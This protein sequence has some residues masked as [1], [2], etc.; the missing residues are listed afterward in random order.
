MK[1]AAPT[2]VP[3]DV[4][5]DV[6]PEYAHDPRWLLVERILAT[7]DFERSPRLSDFLRHICQ[8]TLEGR[9]DT[10]SE[11]YL[12]EA[13]FGRKPEYDSNADTIVRSHALRLRRRLEQYFQR[14]GKSEPLR[15]VIPRGGYVPTFLPA[16]VA[17]ASATDVSNPDSISSS[18]PLTGLH[19]APH[20]PA[21]DVT[22]LSTATAPI[23]YRS[24]DPVLDARALIDRYRA[25]LAASL[26]LSLAL[27]AVTIYLWHSLHIARAGERRDRNHPLW[28]R[29][30]NGQEPTHIVLGDSGLV[31]FHATA[32][33]YVSLQ[34]YVN[35]D[36]SKQMPYV[37]HVEPSFARFLAGRRYTSFVDA[38]T[39][40]RLLRLPEARPD[41]TLVHFSRDMRLDDFKNGNIIMIGAQ[42]ANP[43]IELFEPSMDFVFSIDT[44]DHHSV[45][46]NRHPQPRELRVYAPQ[47]IGPR[48]LYAVIAF[49]PNLNA[50]GNVLLLE[51]IS[52]AATESAVDLVMDDQRLLPILRRI[53]RPD[54][55]LP[56]FEMLLAT[57]VVKDSPAPAQVVAVHLHP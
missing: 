33:R 27:L 30:F 25:A 16:S 31:L 57:D 35:N 48:Q 23:P 10:I 28:S 42:E 19:D 12:G 8:L 41:S 56:H 53:R 13:L 34:D 55:T 17:L 38:T 39:A 5:K 44:P 18:S 9:E 46:L 40:V 26:V 6:Q 15:L 54:G 24:A 2:A 1:Q 51:G 47:P 7:S 32:R 36:L 4:E 20:Q 14:A 52:M 3:Q 49:L 21:W 43:W 22:S 11:Q 50:N 37:Q 29:L 45:F